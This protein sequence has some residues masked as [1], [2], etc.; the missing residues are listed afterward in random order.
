MTILQVDGLTKHFGGLTAVKD[1]SFS[2]GGGEIVGLIGPN[3]AGKTTCFNLI[4]GFFKPTAGRIIFK[5]KDVT[6][7]PDH[8]LA[9]QGLVRTFQHTSLFPKLD[10]LSNIVIG[11]HRYRSTNWVQAVFDTKRFRQDEKNLWEK[12]VRVLEFMNMSEI[13]KELA[14]SLAYGDQRRLEIAIALAAE[15]EL[16]LLD[17]PAAGM[18]PVESIELMRLIKEIQA[19]GI[20]VLLVEHDM[21]LVMGICDRIV[22]LNYG[23]KLAEGTPKQIREDPEV[24]KVY[25]GSSLKDK[26][27]TIAQ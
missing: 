25:L 17:E 26:T 12:A 4:S 22:V 9:T 11:A 8:L 2:V 21:K 19:R 1:V 14:G 13:R 24:I 16:L 3:G 18:N 6:F 7:Q 27:R 10:V 5:G 23:R 20:H 15:P